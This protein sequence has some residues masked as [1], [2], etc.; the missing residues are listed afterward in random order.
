M[1]AEH[2]LSIVNEFCTP[3]SIDVLKLLAISSV[4]TKVIQQIVQKVGTPVI[5]TVSSKV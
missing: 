5:V 4:K 1:P 2:V 3:C